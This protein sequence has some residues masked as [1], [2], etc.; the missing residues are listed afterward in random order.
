MNL[1]FEIS[2]S[3]V[4]KKVVKKA[5]AT[6]ALKE[7]ERLEMPFEKYLLLKNLCSEVTALAALGEFFNLPYCEIDMLEIDREL[8]DKF[9][10]SYLK[11]HKVIPVTIDKD[12]VL[13]L[14]IARPLDYVALSTL[15][16]FYSGKM[17]FILVPPVQVDV[18]IDTVATVQ[19]TKTALSDLQREKD[20]KLRVVFNTLFT[21]LSFLSYYHF[22]HNPRLLL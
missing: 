20:K 22:R 18:F 13:L 15:A 17:D 5:V 8:L 19:S 14:A 6:S 16:T 2:Q 10:F 21:I 9:S 3:F 12:G 7:C 4:Y 11:K 1:N